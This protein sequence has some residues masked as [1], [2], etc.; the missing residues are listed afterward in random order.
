MTQCSRKFCLLAEVLAKFFGTR[1]FG[2]HDLE[3]DRLIAVDVESIRDN[4]VRSSRDNLGNAVPVRKHATNQAA[5]R[6]PAV[7]DRL[8]CI[9]IV[10][11]HSAQNLPLPLDRVAPGTGRLLSLRCGRCGP[12]Y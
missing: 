9:E 10:A 2:T 6:Q 4:R 1:K 12:A 7:V 8:S 11:V 3:G 5:T